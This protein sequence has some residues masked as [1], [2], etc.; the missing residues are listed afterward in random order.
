[1]SEENTTAIAT[2]P[3][4]DNAATEAAEV[5]ETAPESSAKPDKTAPAKA[6]K[7]SEDKAYRLSEIIDLVERK[8][9]TVLNEED[10]AIYDAHVNDGLQPKK[11]PKAK[12]S[13]K[14][15]EDSKEEKAEKSEKPEEPKASKEIEDAVS[16]AMKEVGA[17]SPAELK[18]KIRELRAAVSGKET[19]A[20][21][22][23]KADLQ[24]RAEN[25]EALI[26]DLVEG[27]TQAIQYVEKAYGFKP[28][29]KPPVAEQKA[30]DR[31]FTEDDDVITGGG[32]GKLWDENRRLLERLDEIEGRFKSQ[33]QKAMED[34]IRSRVTAE[35]VD[36]MIA[37]SSGLPGVKDLPNLRNL[38]VDRIIHGKDDPR[39]SAFEEIFQIAE[40]HGVN[41]V[42]IPLKSALLIKQG[43]DAALSIERAK[44]DG[45]KEAYSHRVPKSLSSVT[46][47]EAQP[48]TI[49]DEEIRLMS[50]P[51]GYK[52]IPDHWY[53]SNGN[54]AKAKIPKKAWQ[55]LGLDD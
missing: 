42:P 46:R 3:E 2:A 52:F 36:D 9:E 48:Q 32:L 8:P 31:P 26:R 7:V 34:G 30:Q 20:V 41:G 24:R 33:Q 38:I 5:V 18:A 43:R 35:I 44:E 39:L 13:E 16:E 47:E 49:T 15:A 51:N 10:Q 11:R 6:A 50:G 19:K 14:E 53:D 27:K 28:A 1:M 54:L 45:R 17:K 37:V 22:E 55:A 12:E 29:Y 23:L 40:E 25:T 4:M 21:S